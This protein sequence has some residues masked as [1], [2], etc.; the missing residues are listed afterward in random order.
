MIS[1]VINI[2]NQ[3]QFTQGASPTKFIG[4]M[5]TT[6]I[7]GILLFGVI[8]TYGIKNIKTNIDSNLQQAKTEKDEFINSIE[9]KSFL[10]EYQ[11]NNFICNQCGSSIPWDSLFCMNCGDS[12]KDEKVNQ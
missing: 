12:T 4:P 10:L 2:F 8:F 1:E 9:N 3:G 11:K 7:I 6:F 5:V